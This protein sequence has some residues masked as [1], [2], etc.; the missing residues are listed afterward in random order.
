MGHYRD[1]GVEASMT[2]VDRSRDSVR[3]YPSAHARM[4]HHVCLMSF[5]TICTAWPWFDHVVS[6]HGRHAPIA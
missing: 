5:G 2:G 6:C 1:S 4:F 3:A